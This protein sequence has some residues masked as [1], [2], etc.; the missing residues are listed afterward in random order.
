MVKVANA[1]AEWVNGNGGINGHP[2]TMNVTDTKGDAAAAQAAI[3][4]EEGKNP[5]AWVLVTPSTESAMAES[6][7]ASG[8]PVIGVG[9][10]PSVWGGAIE[11]FKLA[12]SPDPGA[13]VAC[14]LP[15]A[16]PTS[17][18]FGAVVDEQVLGAQAAG[19][20]TLAVAACA[21][22]DSCSQAEPIFAADAKALGL[23]YT[24]LVKISSTAADYT[25]E[26]IKFV[27]DGVDFLQ[28]SA[29]GAVG[30]RMWSDCADQGYTGIFGASA[31]SVSGDILK[32][33]GIKLAGGLNG[34]PW[35]VDDA[36]V[37]EFRDVMEAGGV[38]ADEYSSPTA[39][40]L[41]AALQLFAKANADL[42]DTPTKDDTLAAMYALNGETLDG[43]LAPVTFTQGQPA[44]PR[45]CFW[46]YTLTD[47]Q[48][49]NPL[50]GLKFQCYPPES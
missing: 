10:N 50:G 19:A 45:T 24:G 41:Y 25:S 17:T 34:F 49:E 26:C 30:A 8:I 11:A 42:G 13:P 46:P 22:V 6:L 37:K 32:V 23:G 15:N 43:L 1:W 27:Q 20:K 40:G 4:S 47:G 39:T 29:A 33:D 14:A 16:F 48:F 3:V 5:L 18:T 35:W 9:Y 12:C 21:E 31:G 7:A 44:P 2:V 38:S 36:P 28:I